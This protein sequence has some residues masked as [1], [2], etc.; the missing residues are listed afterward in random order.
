MTAKDFD[1]WCRSFLEIDSLSS[2]DISLNGIQV[3][4]DGSPVKTVAFAVDASLETINRAR[5]LGAEVLFVHHG[6]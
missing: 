1:L 5:E 4:R 6:R 2:I 3:D